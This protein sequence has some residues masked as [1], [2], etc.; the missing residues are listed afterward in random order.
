MKDIIRITF[1]NQ[2]CHDEVTT[3]RVEDFN[4]ESEFDDC[5]FGWWG[6]VYVKVHREDYDKL[7]E[8]EKA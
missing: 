8:D 1:L 2:D 4:L 7:K 5:V 3:F 6:D